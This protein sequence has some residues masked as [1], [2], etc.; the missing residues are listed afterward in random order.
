MDLGPWIQGLGS[1]VTQGHGSKALDPSTKTHKCVKR[2]NE[3]LRMRDYHNFPLNPS[4]KTLLTIAAIDIRKLSPPSG[5]FTC[6]VESQRSLL[7]VK[8]S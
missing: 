1:K 2:K 3:F 6:F 7:I 8:A 4:D 5:E